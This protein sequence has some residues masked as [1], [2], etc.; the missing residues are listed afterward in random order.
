M[1]TQEEVQ[2]AKEL[3]FEVIS[4]LTD[5]PQDGTGAAPTTGNNNATQTTCAAPLLGGHSALTLMTQHAHKPAAVSD[6]GLGVRSVG[7]SSEF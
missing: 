7:A 2:M 6:V 1:M 3:H 4:L 5:L